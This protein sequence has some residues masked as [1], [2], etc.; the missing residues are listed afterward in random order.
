MGHRGQEGS[1][2]VG[3]GEG[4]KSMVTEGGPTWGGEPTV[5]YTD[6]VLQICTSETHIIALPYVTQ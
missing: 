1:G 2:E 6:D 4:P 3:K 5:Q